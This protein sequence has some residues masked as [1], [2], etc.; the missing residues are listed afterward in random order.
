MSSGECF[1]GSL[2]NFGESIYWVFDGDTVQKTMLYAALI[3]QGLLRILGV[4]LAELVW[5]G[6]EVIGLSASASFRGQGN[7]K[8]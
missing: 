3:D 6:P 5:N 4:L 7:P 1:G 2:A 8:P